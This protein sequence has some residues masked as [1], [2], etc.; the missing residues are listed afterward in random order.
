MVKPASGVPT[1]ELEVISLPGP[2]SSI[3]SERLFYGDLLEEKGTKSN[4]LAAAE[5]L[6]VQSLT[7]LK[8]DIQPLF[9][10]ADCKSPEQVPIKVHSVCGQTPEVNTVTNDDDV[11]LSWSRKGVRGAHAPDVVAANPVGTGTATDAKCV[12][13]PSES[14]RKRKRKAVE[15]T[16][17]GED[18]KYVTRELQ[19]N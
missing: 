13:E 17:K 10:E 9:S 6:V 5:E 19:K 15:S 12:E 14:E 7:S 4:I 2:V 1:E 3:M 8:G 18:R 11:P 16:P